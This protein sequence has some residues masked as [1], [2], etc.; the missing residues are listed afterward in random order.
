MKATITIS[1]IDFECTYTV[2][3]AQ[4]ETHEWP[5]NPEYIDDLVITHKGTD[6]TDFLED[7]GREIETMLLNLHD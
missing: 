2:E 1:G 5:G 3:P 7:R 6:F 4:A